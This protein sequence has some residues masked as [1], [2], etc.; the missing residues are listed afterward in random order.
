MDEKRPR[1]KS[2]S[3]GRAEKLGIGTS[4]DCRLRIHSSIKNRA[5]RM[6]I[7]NKKKQLE[8]KVED[9]DIEKKPELQKEAPVYEKG[10]KDEY[11]NNN[12]KLL[13][14]IIH[15]SLEPHTLEKL[16]RAERLKKSRSRKIRSIYPAQAVVRDYIRKFREDHYGAEEEKLIYSI[17]RQRVKLLIRYSQEPRYS[18]WLKLQERFE[19]KAKDEKEKTIPVGSK[20]NKYNGIKIQQPNNRTTPTNIYH[21]YK[22]RVQRRIIYQ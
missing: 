9:P 17:A 1:F 4:G 16:A 11:Y 15:P 21:S 13:K 19:E 6:G 20:G 12:H 14:K 7:T 18:N 2:S 10:R 5:E 8:D 3:K 22:A